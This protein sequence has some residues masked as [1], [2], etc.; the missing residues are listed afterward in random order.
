MNVLGVHFLHDGMID[1][2]GDLLSGWQPLSYNT[3]ELEISYKC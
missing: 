1:I 2:D 3:A